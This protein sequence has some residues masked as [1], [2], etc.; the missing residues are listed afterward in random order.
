MSL[1]PLTLALSHPGNGIKL[2]GVFVMLEAAPLAA[3]R[4]GSYP[5]LPSKHPAGVCRS[6]LEGLWMVAGGKTPGS[7]RA[8]TLRLNLMPL[9][10]WERVRGD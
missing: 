2:R 5:W 4:Q 6:A 9:P 1:I 3:I 8:V 7:Q 10:G